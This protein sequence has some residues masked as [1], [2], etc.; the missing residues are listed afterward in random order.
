MCRLLLVAVLLFGV[1]SLVAANSCDTSN[2]VS[3][4][5]AFGGSTFGQGSDPGVSGCLASGA[6]DVWYTFVAPY[7]GTF[8]ATTCGGGTNY[9]SWLEANEGPDCNSLTCVAVDDD[10][11]GY[12]PGYS[13]VVF[14]VAS[15]NRY[16]VRVAGYSTNAGDYGLQ[17]YY[18]AHCEDGIQNQGEENVDCGGPCVACPTCSDGIQ[19]QG[20]T[21]V[22][23]GGPCVMCPTPSKTPTKTPSKTPSKTSS[24]T[25]T[26]TRSPSGTQLF[27][28][29]ATRTASKSESGTRRVSDSPSRTP[30]KTASRS[31]VNSFSNTKTASKTR[32]L[33]RT[34]TSL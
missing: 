10:A 16:H 11:C 31:Q 27:S 17:L 9:D 32:S 5:G 26:P 4:P 13:T 34:P 3:V 8:V 21:G 30:S 19:N 28:L 29:S 1:A 33:S 14:F 15:G 23:C 24:Q 18:D 20:E 7:T 22:D 6:E 25:K 12:P 2:A